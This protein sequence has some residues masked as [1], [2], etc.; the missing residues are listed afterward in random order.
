VR[1]KAFLLAGGRRRDGFPRPATSLTCGRAR[2]AFMVEDRRR[3]AT[4]IRGNA[5]TGGRYGEAAQKRHMEPEVAPVGMEDAEA[6]V[7]EGFA[8]ALPE[9][10]GVE[11]RA[12]ETRG[13]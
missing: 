7:P 5:T 10:E 8:G 1:R 4:R 6:R 13:E 11:E 9:N 3:E 2:L 12:E